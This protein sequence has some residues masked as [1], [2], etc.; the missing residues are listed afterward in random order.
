MTAILERT[1]PALAGLIEAERAPPS[2]TR[3]A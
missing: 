2:T 1:D 3:C